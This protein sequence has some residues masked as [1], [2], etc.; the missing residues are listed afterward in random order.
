MVGAFWAE[1]EITAIGELA[2]FPT[3]AAG[4]YGV[5]AVTVFQFLAFVV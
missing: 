2:D 5:V 1:E 3:V 4:G